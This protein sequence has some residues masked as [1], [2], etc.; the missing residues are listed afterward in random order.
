MVM[1]YKDPMKYFVQFF[2]FLQH[3]NQV[4]NVLT[5][6]YQTTVDEFPKD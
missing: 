4:N 5:P 1:C 2:L 6:E 3:L